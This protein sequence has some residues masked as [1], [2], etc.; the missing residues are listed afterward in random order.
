M[1]DLLGTSAALMAAQ[2]VSLMLALLDGPGTVAEFARRRSIDPRATERVLEVLVS[3]GIAEHVGDV[4]QASEE[5]RAAAAEMP[6]GMGFGVALWSRTATFLRTG[7]PLVRF[8]S[9]A[10]AERDVNYRKVVESLSR[11]FT[12]PARELAARIDEA[13]AHILDM[14]CGAGIWSLAIA[15]R[16]AGTRVTGLDLPGVLAMFEAR[17]SDMGLGDRISTLAG[18]YHTIDIPE[19][20]FDV[21]IIA[22]VLRLEPAPRAAHIVE[23]AVGAISPGGKLIVVDALAGGTPERERARAVYALHLAMRSAEGTVHSPAEVRAWMEAQ[24]LVIVEEV[25]LEGLS[26]AGAIIGQAK[27]A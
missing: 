20:A 7:D 14:G 10:P 21:V 24:G 8:D 9:A 4:Y 17:A 23:R 12:P 5:F 27:A 1:M 11:I 6:G 15:E 19:R 18:D 3:I 16:F 2:Q 22:N 25:P 26:A 13:P